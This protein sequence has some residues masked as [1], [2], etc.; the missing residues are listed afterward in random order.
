MRKNK[1]D[2]IKTFLLILPVEIGM[3]KIES[4]PWWSFVL[5]VMILGVI[6]TLKKW[7]FR[8]FAVGFAAGFIIWAGASLYF[9][10][11]F[12]GSILNKIGLLLFVPKVIVL[13]L[14][15]LTGGLLAGL[16]LYA[17]KTMVYERNPNSDLKY[18]QEF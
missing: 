14:S 12:D 2:T 9:D 4:L 10:W 3:Q 8:G 1:S 13:L 7:N 6:L 11:S 18:R 5:P 16:A 17:G 15:G